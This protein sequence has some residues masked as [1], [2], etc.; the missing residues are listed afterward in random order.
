MNK[1]RVSVSVAQF[2]GLAEYEHAGRGAAGCLTS[3]TL[4]LCVLLI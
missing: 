1:Y 4:T 3:L 2:P